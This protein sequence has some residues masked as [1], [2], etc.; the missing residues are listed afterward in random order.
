MGR[1]GHNRRL[2]RLIGSFVAIAVAIGLLTTASAIAGSPCVRCSATYTG[3]WDL[4][5]KLGRTVPE[6]GT[7]TFQTHLTW[8]STLTWNAAAGN[9]E[10][11]V[12][13]AEGTYQVAGSGPG[14]QDCSAT[15]SPGPGAVSA[16]SFWGS[17]FNETNSAGV[18][19]Q[20]LIE[21]QPPTQWGQPSAALNPLQSSSSQGACGSQ[22]S[23][24]VGLSGPFHAQLHGA[25]CHFNPANGQD[26][27]KSPTHTTITVVD[28]CTGS[29]A[30]GNETSYNA[31]LQAKLIFAG[32][33]S[34]S[35][36]HPTGP[37][38]SPEAKEEALKDMREAAI[39]NAKRY[40][41]P[42]AAGLSLFGAGVLTIGGGI[43]PG[44][45]AMTGAMTASALLPFCNATLTR[46]GK[47]Y[48]TYKDP[49][50][51]DIHVLARPRQA[52]AAS[53][54]SCGRW[55]GNVARVC[56]R[57]RAAYAQLDGAAARVAA[58]SAAIEETVSR[59]TAA[60]K[61]GDEA[62]AG[63][64]AADLS[65]LAREKGVAIA[66]EAA[67]GRAVEAALKGARAQFRLTKRQSGKVIAGAERQL[68]K[69]GISAAELRAVDPSGLQPAAANLLAGLGRL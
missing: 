29:G 55:H 49:P 12:V 34:G 52:R 2:C 16:E 5:Y 35:G 68:A 41:I 24:S 47:D 60:R 63:A 19:V 46:L 38:P 44:M 17:T 13:A 37:G 69:Q 45:I 66:A 25:E 39:P 23:T 56:K 62:A 15:L 4:T 59:G 57:L 10:W 54:P 42:Y 20:Y 21:V 61:Q 8:T 65:T 22:S 33:V 67:A 43:G 53:L 64:Q 36:P 6:I 30:E 7:T 32:D 14:G 3:T 50:Q 28:S 48:R 40:C 27:I 11:R 9:N 18:P 1:Y 51:W 58:V 26:E 31:A